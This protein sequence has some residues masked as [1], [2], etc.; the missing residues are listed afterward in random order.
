MV[1]QALVLLVAVEVT[2]DFGEH[3]NQP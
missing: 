2:V 1:L 3:R